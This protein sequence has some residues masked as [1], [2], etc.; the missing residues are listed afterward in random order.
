MFDL[1]TE[2]AKI[3]HDELVD[4]ATGLVGV[5]LYDPS[6]IGVVESRLHRANPHAQEDLRKAIDFVNHLSTLAVGENN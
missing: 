2:I 6:L 5:S 1:K 4:I 3:P